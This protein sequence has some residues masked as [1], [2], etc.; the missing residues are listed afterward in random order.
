MIEKR[1]FMADGENTVVIE[2]EILKTGPG[3]CHLELRPLIAFRGYH[4]LTQANHDLNGACDE[5][6]GVVSIQPYTALPRL[7]FAHNAK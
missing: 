4:D 7:W 5:T 1:V 6:A 2:Y 3:G